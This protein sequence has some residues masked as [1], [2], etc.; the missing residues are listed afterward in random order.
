MKFTCQQS[1][2]VKALATVQKATSNGG[3]LPVLENILISATG[4]GVEFSATD[5]DISL[6]VK[7]EAQVQNEG[8]ITIPAKTIVSWAS[9]LDDGEIEI[10][11]T[12]GEALSL[13]CGSAKTTIK[14]I[15][16][17]E[18]PSLPLVNKEQ[19]GTI[20]IQ[21]LKK[22]LHEVVFAASSTG[23]RP[24]LSGVLFQKEAEK[25]I[26][27]ATDS[28]RLSEKKV[29]FQEE[30]KEDISCIVPAKT[31]LELD[32]I[33]SSDDEG[34]VEIILSEH[35]VLFYT[36]GIRLVSRLIEGQFPN[37]KQILPKEHK[38]TLSVSRRSLIQTVKRVGIFARE[39]KNNI[40]LFLN[41]NTLKITTDATEIGAEESLLEVKNAEGGENAVALNAQFLLDILLVL[42]GDDI[43]I[44]I[45]EKLHPLALSS[46][47]NPEFTHII[48][49]LKM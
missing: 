40:K 24:V 8:A 18:F 12:N 2:F 45:G 49:P 31:L 3:T 43:E 14:G 1:E 20:N 5:L 37:Y 47:K 27:V 4:Q 6:L 9:L 26:L 41:A 42:Q 36:K 39:N 25:L 30:P 23:S 44:R 10:L 17:D 21:D 29:S 38:N 11:K 33:L 46:T 16:S 28:Y 7:I 22:A 32:R 13:R 15:S 35:Q 19:Y 34:V 48:M